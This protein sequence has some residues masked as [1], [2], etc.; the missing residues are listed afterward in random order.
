[1]AMPA[2]TFGA[3]E[4]GGADLGD[5][6]RRDRLIRVADA[7]LAHPEAPLP[8]KFHDPAGYTACLRLFRNPRVSHAAVLEPHQLRTLERM[9]ALAGPVLILHDTTELDFSGRRTPRGGLGPIGNGGGRGLLCHNSLAL[10]P[11]SRALLGLV[12]QQLVT[13]V[14]TPR[15]QTRRQQR[16]RPTRESRLWQ[17]GLDEIGP[18]P[19]GR[20]WLHVADRGADS[21]EFLHALHGRRLDY[22]VRAQHDRSLGGGRT[23]FGQAR[24]A[25]AEASWELE[26]TATAGRPARRARVRASRLAV[27][28][29]PPHN[30]RGEY[31]NQPLRATVVRVWEEGAAGVEP[32]EWFLLTSRPAEAPGA[33]REL[34]G[35][36]SQRMVVEEYHK[37]QKTGVGI[38]RL[39][40]E[41]AAGLRAAIAVL[42]VVAVAVVNLRVLGGDPATA[43]GPAS[44]VVPALWVRVLSQ[45]RRGRAEPLT[46]AEFVRELAVLGGWI[47][48]KKQPP[49]WQVLWRGWERL[50]TLIDYELSRPSCD[51]L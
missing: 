17:R 21:F 10:D 42:S 27:E 38:E 5:R 13:R 31:P 15:G 28:L 11:A 48:R 9:E 30:R 37:G 4:F 8:D 16:Q 50:H 49:G 2:L 3:E 22:L 51:R 25:A 43:G 45:R 47:P 7:C 24:Q 29:P 19:A 36:Y 23:L 14:P 32:L 18:T 41:T 6:R 39:A 20:L 1:M 34:A 46:A 44:A 26:L 33:L 12:S 35:Y 40:L